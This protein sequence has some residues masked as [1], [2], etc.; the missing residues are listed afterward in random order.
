MW[1]KRREI[2]LISG[3]YWIFNQNA[4]VCILKSAEALAE[5]FKFSFFTFGLTL[6]LENTFS[7]TTRNFFLQQKHQHFPLKKIAKT[8]KGTLIIT[9]KQ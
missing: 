9:Q 1:R 8:M 4:S 5:V 7:D 3:K 6:K 2:E